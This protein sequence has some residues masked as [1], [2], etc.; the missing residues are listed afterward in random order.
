[1]WGLFKYEKI[2]SSIIDAL[3]DQSCILLSINEVKYVIYFGTEEVL[4]FFFSYVIYQH[5]AHTAYTNMSF[6]ST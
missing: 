1:M 2:G 4:F 3:S 5:N 6:V